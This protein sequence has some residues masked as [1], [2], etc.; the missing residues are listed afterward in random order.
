MD[1]DFCFGVSNVDEYFDLQKRLNKL[2]KGQGR[3]T[4]SGFILILDTGELRIELY[5]G[6]MSIND[7]LIKAKAIGFPQNT[8]YCIDGKKKTY[9]KRQTID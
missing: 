8:V 2:L 5:E 9:L 3:I 7:F 1:I 6:G 4:D